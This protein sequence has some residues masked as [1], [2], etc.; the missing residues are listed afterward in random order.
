MTS[1]TLAGRLGKAIRTRRVRL[2]LSQEAF[3]AR[4]DMHA[5]YYARIERGEKN[6]TL[7][8]LKRV[9]DG[10]GLRMATLLD[11]AGL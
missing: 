9:A 7:A 4:I 8:T 10:M 5:A 6:V 2:G 11:D 1:A 3:A